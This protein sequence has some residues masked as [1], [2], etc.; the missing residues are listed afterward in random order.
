M[1][2]FFLLWKNICTRPNDK[3]CNTDVWYTKSKPKEL[4]THSS[5]FSTPVPSGSKIL[6]AFRMFSSG[7]VPGKFLLVRRD[8][9]GWGWSM[10]H[11]CNWSWSVPLSFSPNMLR[12]TVKL[13]GPGASLSM[14]SSSSLPTF[15][16]PGN[17][18]TVLYIHTHTCVHM[19]KC[20]R[21]S[22]SVKALLNFS[23][24]TCYTNVCFHVHYVAYPSSQHLMRQFEYWS[25]PFH[26]WGPI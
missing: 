24:L 17:K 26:Y 23:L 9:L 13:I 11:W 1:V 22:M 16:R 14:S 5:P 3:I 8:N 6:K 25:I 12:N 10:C 19:E 4:I 7:S 18:H 15:R 2:F 20:H 21:T